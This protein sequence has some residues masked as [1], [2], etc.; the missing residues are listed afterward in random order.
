MHENETESLHFIKGH[1]GILGLF[2]F[3]KIQP[4]KWLIAQETCAKKYGARI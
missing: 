1:N 2:R 3:V 4:K